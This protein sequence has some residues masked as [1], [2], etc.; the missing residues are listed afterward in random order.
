MQLNSVLVAKLHIN[1]KS[2]YT[3]VHH[4]YK[5]SLQLFNLVAY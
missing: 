1:G 2:K 4:D 3:K 5:F